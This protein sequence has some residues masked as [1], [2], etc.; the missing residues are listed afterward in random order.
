MGGIPRDRVIPAAEAGVATIRIARIGR[1]SQDAVVVGEGRDPRLR[2]LGDCLDSFEGAEHVAPVA[3]LP[4]EPAERAPHFGEE[5]VA[6][7]E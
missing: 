1:H 2:T 7:V 5:I 4:Q 3:T 6:E